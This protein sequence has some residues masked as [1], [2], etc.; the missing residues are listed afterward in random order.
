MDNPTLQFCPLQPEDW[1]AVSAIYQQG[2]DTGNATFA[3]KA[4]STWEEWIHGKLE[5]CRL[6]ARLDGKTVAWA[7]LTPVSTRA[8][9]RGVA[10]LSIYV[11]DEARGRGVGAALLEALIHDSEEQD[12]W[13]LEALVFPENSASMQLHLKHGFKLLGV[14]Q[15]LGYMTFGPYAGHWRDVALLERRSQVAGMWIGK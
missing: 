2:I 12:I 4:P 13:M 6:V 15:R 5:R 3:E 7:V 10:E 11:A 9:Y 8:V 14:R 1:P